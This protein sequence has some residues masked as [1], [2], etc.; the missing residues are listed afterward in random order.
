M[1]LALHCLLSTL[2]LSLVSLV[3]AVCGHFGS[4]LKEN[5]CLRASLTSSVSAA[6]TAFTS[7]RHSGAKSESRNI[8]T[9]AMLKR[10][11]GG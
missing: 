6:E 8:L 2:G 1:P 11:A 10:C 7:K 5:V 9:R 4:S 3:D